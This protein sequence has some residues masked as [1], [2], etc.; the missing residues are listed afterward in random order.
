MP[1]PERQDVQLKRQ[2][3][4]HFAAV[5]FNG[6]AD[7]AQVS[8]EVT[9]ICFFQYLGVAVTRLG[10]RVPLA[11][12]I[13]TLKY[14]YRTTMTRRLLM[15]QAKLKCAWNCA[16]SQAEAVDCGRWAVAGG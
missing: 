1:S 4:G 9:V 7:E 11:S 5:M 6:M 12:I 14:G 2:P 10:L 8:T 3:G 13:Q 16:G 15:P